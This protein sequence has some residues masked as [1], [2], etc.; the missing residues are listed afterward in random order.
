MGKL[1][2][3]VAV[4]TGGNSGI[5][6]ASAKLFVAEGAHVFVTGRRQPELDAAV[7]LRAEEE[8]VARQAQ[9]LRQASR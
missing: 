9:E 2:G 7:A 4:V 6:L 1:Q 8:R 3:K 5:G